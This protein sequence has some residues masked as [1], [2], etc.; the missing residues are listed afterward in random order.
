MTCLTPNLLK[1]KITASIEETIKLKKLSE[2]FQMGNEIWDLYIK[3][4][5]S[6]RKLVFKRQSVI[7]TAE[8]QSESVKSRKTKNFKSLL[9]PGNNY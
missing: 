1:K 3:I 8:H 7:A 5:P 9:K 4:D 2:G 6:L